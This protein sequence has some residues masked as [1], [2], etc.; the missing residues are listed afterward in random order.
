MQNCKGEGEGKVEFFSAKCWNGRNRADLIESMIPCHDT[1]VVVSYLVSST[2]CLTAKSE[3]YITVP[4][5][6]QRKVEQNRKLRTEKH[7]IDK[8]KDE[9]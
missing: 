5:H 4:Q 3:D 2:L 6:L 9:V 1:Q 8:F 7:S